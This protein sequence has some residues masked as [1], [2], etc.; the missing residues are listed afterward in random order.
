MA[1]RRW[2]VTALVAMLVAVGL[3]WIRSA[4]TRGRRGRSDRLHRHGGALGTRTADE[5][6]VLARRPRLRRGEVGHRPRLRLALRPDAVGVRRPADG[7]LQLRRRRHDRADAAP[8]LPRDAVR[9]RQL[10]LRRA[11]RWHRADLRP[12]GPDVRHLRRRDRPGLHGERARD[13]TR[14]RPATSG[15]PRRCSSGTGASRAR[16]AT[17]CRTCASGRTECSTSARATARARTPPTT[18]SSATRAVIRPPR[19]AR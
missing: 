3:T 4:S 16:R 2:V 10:R 1:G 11:D 7:G 13:A 12:A 17:R 9:V 8:E 6:R 19:L 15:A 18:A 5:H 14:P